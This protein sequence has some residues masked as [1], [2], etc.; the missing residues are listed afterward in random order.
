M[1]VTTVPTNITNQTVAGYKAGT[2]L[3]HRM[4]HLAMVTCP[5]G[6][7]AQTNTSGPSGYFDVW[8]DH[9]SNNLVIDTTG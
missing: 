6:S 4:T 3:G 8:Y 2:G 1:A 9:D 7:L 5:P